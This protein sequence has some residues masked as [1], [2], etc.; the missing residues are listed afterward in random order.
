MAKFDSQYPEQLQPEGDDAFLI[1]S[2]ADR[3]IMSIKFKTIVDVIAGRM[4][5]ELMTD[6]EHIAALAELNSR[7][8][9]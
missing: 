2:S 1:A 3:N 5:P 9:S 7:L 6:A 4:E 8:S